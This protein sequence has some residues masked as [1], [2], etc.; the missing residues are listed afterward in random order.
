MKPYKKTKLKPIFLLPTFVFIAGFIILNVIVHIE[1]FA[2]KNLIYTRTTLNA[3][4]YANRLITDLNQGIAVTDALEQIIISENGGVNNFD[5]VARNLMT[6]YIHSI[7]LAPGGVVESIYPETGNESGKIDLLGDPSRSEF[8]HYAKQHNVITM[9]GPFELNQGSMGIAIR[10][11]VFLKNSDGSSN[12]WGF[13]VV[14]IKVPEIFENSIQTLGNFGYEYS[15][16]KTVSALNPEYEEVCSSEGKIKKP[17]SYEFELGSCSWKLDVMPRDGWSVKS[18]TIGIYVGGMIIVLLI[19]GLLAVLI[20]LDEQKKQLLILATTDTLTGLLNRSGFDESAKKFVLECPNTPCVGVTF[21]IDDFKFINDRYGHAFG[22]KIL[23]QLAD[24]MKS[25]LPTDSIMGRIGGDEF[26]IILKNTTSEKA[27]KLLN[28]FTFTERSFTFNGIKYSYSISAGYAEY[29][30]YAKNTSELFSKADM[31][32]YEVKLN[33]KHGCLEYSEKLMSHKRSQLGFA[34]NEVSEHLPGAFL[35]Y[36]ADSTGKTDEILFANNEMI[37]FVGC[38][39]LEDFLKFTH[40]SFGNLIRPDE[41]ENV[42]KSIW[43]QINERSDG[44]NDYVQFHLATKSGVYKPVLDHG[45]IV[46]N[47]YY[48]RVFYVLMMDSEFIKSHYIQE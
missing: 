28:D 7:Q 44:S 32:L 35:I 26:C 48:G 20:M 24:S 14:I 36:R 30:K 39:D 22:D 45:R 37:K 47:A 15:L 1:Y 11:P 18:S 43:K 9:Q 5:T 16:S 12:F 31:A 41:R 27:S 10:N 46:D 2:G 3:T 42:E 8:V 33:G 21:D 23:Q 13:A 17:V 19:P 4:T 29:P 25:L 38:D 6:Y 40:H 34:L